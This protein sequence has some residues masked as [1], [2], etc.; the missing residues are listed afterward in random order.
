MKKR[1]KIH[2]PLLMIITMLA[3][4]LVPGTAHAA[5]AEWRMMH[6]EQDA[7]VLGTITEE[8]EDGFR[9]EVVE[10][11][12]CK[13][14]AVKGRMLPLEDVPGEMI[15]SIR[16]EYQYSYHGKT[17]PEVGDHI[18]IS[19]DKKGDVWEQG[20]LVM[21][22]S[23]A[24]S[25]TVEFATPENMSNSEY[26]WQLFVN[27][28][29]E[30]TNFAYEGEDILYSDGEIVFEADKHREEFVEQESS[31]HEETISEM[32]IEED[33]RG[34]LVEEETEIGEVAEIPIMETDSATTAIIGGADGPTSVFIAGK[35]GSGVRTAGLIVGVLVVAGLIAGGIILGKKL[36]RK[37]K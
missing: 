12:W 10:A 20:W 15:V 28:G 11:L 18:F 35:L 24:D 21:E 31:A 3:S 30:K 34:E 36:N 29:G 26:A 27:S 6:G 14:D 2:I 8:T 37:D 16:T 1:M 19:V 9:V 33:G 32:V 7:L 5:D 22:G 13:Q 4:L 17:I 23:C 25:A